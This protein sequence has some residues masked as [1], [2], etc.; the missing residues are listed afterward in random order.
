MKCVYKT[1]DI[2]ELLTAGYDPNGVH[3]YDGYCEKRCGETVE[4]KLKMARKLGVD[5]PEPPAGK[6]LLEWVKELVEKGEITNDAI[7]RNK[8]Q[9]AELQQAEKELPSLV[10]LSKNLK[11]HTLEIYKY[12][13][14]TGRTKVS[15]EWEQAR[16]NVCNECGNMIIKNNIMRCT[17]CGC[18]LKEGLPLIG[19]KAEYEAL[20]CDLGK[21]QDIDKEFKNGLSK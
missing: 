9:K 18:C 12:Y 6:D 15:D 7:E 2:C 20:S 4:Q 11:R 8:K 1:K 3:I 13:K 16:I 10:Q 17:K 14:A 5:I 21:W 19:G